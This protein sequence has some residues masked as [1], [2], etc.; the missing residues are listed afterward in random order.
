MIDPGDDILANLSVVDLGGH[1]RAGT[2]TSAELTELCLDRIRRFD[3]KLHSFLTVTEDIARHQAASAD[4][5]FR[6][7]RNL[8]P[9]QGIPYGLKDIFDVAGVE[10]SCNSN[11][12][13]GAFPAEK[14]S[15]LYKRLTSQGAVLL[16]K[17][18]TH[19]LALGGPSTEL[20]FPVARNPWNRSHFAGASSSGSAVAVAARFVPM[21]FGSDTSGSIRGPAS[22]CGIVGFK[23]TYGYVSRAGLV[24]LSYS[25]D[26]VGPLARSVADCALVAAA[27]VG[28]DQDDPTSRDPATVLDR[29]DAGGLA[30]R[31]IGVVENYLTPETVMDR[32]VADAIEGL[33]DLVEKAGG[34]VRPVK[35]PPFAEYDACGRIIMMAEAYAIHSEALARVPLSFARPTYQR[36]IQGAFLSAKDYIWAQQ[37]RLRLASRFI[38]AM[39]GLDAII[40]PGS[41]FP[42]PRLDEFGGDWPPPA[43]LTATRTIV[44]N[45]VGAP[46]L[47]LPIGLTKEG[48][49]M[50]AQIIGLPHRD[51]LTLAVASGIENLV[52]FTS[53]LPPTVR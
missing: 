14:S 12:P 25:L 40:C 19:E 7:G 30:G 11:V 3:G 17:L 15:T 50:G 45:V 21:S 32:Q 39:R 29:D 6:E 38:D 1:L 31:M 4:A 23:P 43:H 27:V 34:I 44:A 47:S 24:P 52:E 18:N 41:L 48:L 53:A 35:L 2:V 13:I 51:S 20:P 33:I 10:T 36:I 8:G 49:P 37:A 22:C 9:L 26:H 46:A 5:A 28:R 42:P 16:G